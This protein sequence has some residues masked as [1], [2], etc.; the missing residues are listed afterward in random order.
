MN[1]QARQKARLWSTRPL[2][3]QATRHCLHFLESR[4][5]RRNLKSVAMV[6]NL[7]SANAGDTREAGAISGSGRSPGEGRGYPLQYP[8]LENPMDRGAWRATV[9]GVT[10]SRTELKQ[11]EHVG[12]PLLLRHFLQL[13]T[14]SL[15]YEAWVEICLELSLL[16]RD[17]YSPTRRY[18]ERFMRLE[19]DTT[20]TQLPAS[21]L[22][23]CFFSLIS[24][25]RKKK[26]QY[27]LSPCH[28]V[29]K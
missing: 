1:S 17:I 22:S 21:V 16:N 27:S 23:R 6:K 11:L 20:A 28:R 7:S 25:I 9:Q 13:E 26:S 10:K 29:L 19:S 24:P 5:F 4:A 3:S 14:T 18:T 8:C 15:E 2:V 12:K